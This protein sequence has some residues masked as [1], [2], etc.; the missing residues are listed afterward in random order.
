MACR[1]CSDFVLCHSMSLC[2]GVDLLEER[3]QHPSALSCTWPGFVPLPQELK[4]PS[5]LAHMAL[6]LAITN[7]GGGTVRDQSEFVSF[8]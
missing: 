5:W 3:G 6:P 1:L 4:C 2:W 8:F 7:V